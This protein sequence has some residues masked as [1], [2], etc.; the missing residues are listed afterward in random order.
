MTLAYYVMRLHAGTVAL[1]QYGG[2]A[3]SD[4]CQ[5]ASSDHAAVHMVWQSSGVPSTIHTQLGRALLVLLSTARVFERY[6]SV[7]SMR[8]DQS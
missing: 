4:I 6:F 7:N 2:A 5:I 1:V 8:S 3:V